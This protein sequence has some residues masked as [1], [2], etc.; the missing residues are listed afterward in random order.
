MSKGSKAPAAPNP[1]MVIGAQTA[2]NLATADANRVNQQT[3]FG[4][5][6]WSQDPSGRWTQTS[7]YSQPITNLYGGMYDVANRLQPT[8]AKLADQAGTA[9]T[10]P[11]NFSGANN[12]FISQGPQPLV[13]NA[14]DAYYAKATGYLDPE[15]GQKQTTLQDQLSRQGIPVGSEAYS[16][17][18][19][20]FDN[21]RNQA[22]G[23]ARDSA[24]GQ[25]IQGGNT[26]FN[27]ALAGQQQNVNQQ[28]LAQQDPLKLLS[29]V[30]GGG[31]A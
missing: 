24:I 16:N 25:G 27:M 13:N 23:A 29:M 4:S 3:P 15:W 12:D 21:S 2:S 18:M 10:N 19:T 11:L 6:M 1:S 7:D 8:A 14:A 17:A 28:Q 26:M 5:S 9:S 22:Y 30:Y 31:T 20:Q